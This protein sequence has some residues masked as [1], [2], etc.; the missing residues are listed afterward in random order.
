MDIRFR[1]P[2]KEDR[3]RIDKFLIPLKNDYVPPF[4]E[5]ERKDE[6][7]DIYG[8]KAKAIIALTQH[9]QLVGYVVWKQY[10]KNKAYGYLANLAVHPKFRR[11]G[12]STKIRKLAFAQIKKAGYKGV[13]YT[14]WHKNIAMI[15]S[16]KKLGMKIAKIYLD[17]KFRGPGGKTLILK[18]DF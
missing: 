4:S 11:K 1:K 3:K 5:E 12:I 8:G 15:E 6:L 18:K 2:K 13:C 10:P 14:T 7:N 16:S 17:E 9:R